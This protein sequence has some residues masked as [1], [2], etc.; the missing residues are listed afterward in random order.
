MLS[1]ILDMAYHIYTDC[2]ALRS[3]S[4][5]GCLGQP[6]RTQGGYW[7]IMELKDWHFCQ[8]LAK[9]LLLLLSFCQHRRGNFEVSTHKIVR[10]RCEKG[11]EWMRSPLEMREKVRKTKRQTHFFLIQLSAVDNFFISFPFLVVWHYLGLFLCLFLYYLGK[12][13]Y[14][15]TFNQSYFISW[16]SSQ[17][18]AYKSLN[19]LCAIP[20]QQPL[21]ACHVTYS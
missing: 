21:P 12:K 14:G 17:V 16:K 10:W 15:I 5:L 20:L 11:F 8:L 18:I 6:R 2:P 7:I 19:I 4:L 9:G 1:I 3:G 13:N